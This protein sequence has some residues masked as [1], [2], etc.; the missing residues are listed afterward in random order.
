MKTSFLLAL[1][2]LMV[3][4]G[5]AQSDSTENTS[6]QFKL[7][8]NYNTNLNYYGRT[9]SLRSS[10]FFPMAEVWFTPKFYVNAAPIFVNN[11]LQ[12]FAYAGTVA[13]VGYQNVTDKTITSLYALKPF[14]QESSDLVQSALQA[15]AGF[16]LSFLNPV[17]NLTGGADV[18]FSDKTDFG[19]TVGLDHVIKAVNEDKSVWVIDPSVYMYAGTQQ[20]QQ[21]YY[22]KN[23]G[24]LLNLPG[25][26]QKVTEN[27]QKFNILAYELS[28]PVIYAKGKWMAIATPS[29]IMPQNLVTVP[30]RPDLSERGSDMFYTNL[31]LKYSF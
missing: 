2:L 27:V 24:G 11:A 19:T 29:Y 1:S 4:A 10:G 23:N 14:Y 5:S 16:S 6:V 12:S 13:T 22:K 15:Q 7:S 3:I 26:Q 21:T 25:N 28:V 31:S 17:V 9:D 30:N 18:K 8:V 20:F